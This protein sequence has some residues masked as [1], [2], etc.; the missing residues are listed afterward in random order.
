MTD[1]VNFV[2]L[3]SKDALDRLQGLFRYSQVGRCVNSVTHDV[4]NFLGVVLNYAELIDM[5]SD[6]SPESQRMVGEIVEGVRKC[7]NLLGVLT[8][9]ARKDKP[10]VSVVNPSKLVGDVL[11][12]RRYDIRINQIQLDEEL[13]CQ[14]AVTLD[15][16]KFELALVYLISN[17]IDAVGDS[18]DRRIKVKMLDVGDAVELV[19][20][21]SGPVVPPEQRDAVFKPFFTTKDGDHLGLGLAVAEAIAQYHGGQLI[22]DPDRGFIFRLPKESK[23]SRSV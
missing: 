3:Q 5:D 16:P 4:N 19:V 13:A 22:Y 12:L 17:A 23:L 8:S 2:D 9:I 14:A 7:S 21:N 6:L 1:N 18:T 10:N 11:D 15:L 20:W